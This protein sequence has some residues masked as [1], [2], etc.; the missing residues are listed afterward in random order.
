M[1]QKIKIGINGTLIMPFSFSFL[2]HFWICVAYLFNVNCLTI[3]K[4]NVYFINWQCK[5]IKEKFVDVSFTLV[6]INDMWCVCV[7]LLVMMKD[8]EGLAVWSPGWHCRETTW[9]LL[10]L[11]ILSSQ[12]ITWYNNIFGV[13]HMG[14]VVMMFNCAF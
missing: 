8:L 3:Y 10:L 2:Q 1:G 4:V 6:I 9:S 13:V 7:H 5:K 14:L 11:M 12:L